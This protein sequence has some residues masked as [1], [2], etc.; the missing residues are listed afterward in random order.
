MPNNTAPPSNSGTGCMA[1]Q[2]SRATVVTIAATHTAR[3]HTAD[4]GIRDECD[5]GHVR[6]N[7]PRFEPLCQA[8]RD[9]ECGLRVG[10]SVDTTND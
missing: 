10:R 2:R 6:D 1:G 8:G 5:L 3:P 7:L 9:A 4:G